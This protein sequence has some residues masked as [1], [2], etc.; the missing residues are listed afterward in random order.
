MHMAKRLTT[1]L[2]ACFPLASARCYGGGAQAPG[3]IRTTAVSALQGACSQLT[4]S[5]LENEA[6]N[7]CIEISE[8]SSSGKYDLVVHRIG[9]NGGTMKID[10]C[11]DGLTK[12]IL[13]C[14]RGGHSRKGDWE[15][16]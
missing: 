10:D 14:S 5:Y 13:G 12:E 7:R 2:L 11:E 3:L 9:K 8:G 1:A 16:M 6:R 4:G 15:Y